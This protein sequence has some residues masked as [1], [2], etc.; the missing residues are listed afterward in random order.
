M[1]SDLDGVSKCAI[2]SLHDDFKY[3]MMST[4]Q[5]MYMQ[6]LI[7]GHDMLVR[8]GTGTGKTIG[9]LLPLL[10]RL[11]DSS[12]NTVATGSTNKKPLLV[13]A[14]IVSP[15]RELA[16]QTLEQAR[17][18]LARCPKS[19]SVH[20]LVGGVRS[21]SGD[22][23]AL[24][25]AALRGERI[26]A[27]VTPGR[28]MEHM[29]ST[30]G[31]SE[32]L[33]KHG[34]VLVLDEVDRLLDPG[35]RPVVMKVAAAMANPERQTLLFTATASKDVQELSR[36]LLKGDDTFLNAGAS[37]AQG[38]AGAA[39]NANVKQEAVLVRADQMVPV[40]REEF[41]SEKD[42]LT[43]IFVPTAAMAST[44][45]SI[46][47]SYKDAGTSVFEIHS[48]LSQGQRSRAV[49]DF[50][51][52]KPPA[53]I[54][55]TDV[56][57]RGLDVSGVTLV[58][59]LGIA[60]DN[61]QVAH[62]VGRTGRGGA[63]GRAL[64]VLAM[65]EERVLRDLIDRE[66]MPIVLRPA[67]DTRSRFL[68]VCIDGRQASIPSC[69]DSVPMIIT[70]DAGIIRGES[71]IIDFVASAKDAVV[72]PVDSDL[73][74]ASDLSREYESMSFLDDGAHNSQMSTS[75]C[76]FLSLDAIDPVSGGFP[77][78]SSSQQHLSAAASSVV[79][80]GGGD[81]IDKMTADFLSDLDG[82]L[83]DMYDYTL[84]KQGVTLMS[85]F[86][87]RAP[88]RYFNEYVMIPYGKYI[89]SRDDKFFLETPIEEE[90]VDNMDF[91]DM[92]FD[93]KIVDIIRS[94]W[95]TL[96]QADR[97]AVWEHLGLLLIL[98]ERCIKEE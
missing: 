3:K 1:F 16:E 14:V 23:S 88:Y 15:A 76:R 73:M 72:E 53:A 63:K 65:S 62:R 25:D 93:F 51:N 74:T 79:G 5:S 54:V 43:V 87:A 89:K 35:F 33:A 59:Q 47:R 22:R 75:S 31:F 96:T 41:L 77:A 83:S 17:R 18:L 34:R 2:E 19:L 98:C 70:S 44:L 58:L 78:F 9:F 29:Q 68:F 30:P 92:K 86:D 66:K 20:A 10:T 55:A 82:I 48:R 84:F 69:V 8:A 24:N 13:A 56:F 27:V 38:S 46:L 94:R 90:N 67:T 6:A 50:K 39:H 97:S 81:V 57:A 71:D 85:S 61:A 32:G 7:N 60:P 37:E 95:Q 21:T 45:A 91:M 64:M 40:I 52:A 26:V 49:S 80:N 28:L 42:G 11:L 12:K 36:S 4:S